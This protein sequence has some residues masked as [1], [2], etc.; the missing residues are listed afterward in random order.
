MTLRE[1]LAADAAAAI[2]GYEETFQLGGKDF[3]C[4][5]RDQPT[6]M[7]LQESGGFIEGV[8]YWLV[9]AKAAFPSRNAWP[10]DGDGINGNAHQV[11]RVTGH[12][13]PAS[14]TLTL[15]IGSFDE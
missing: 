4:V 12:K 11:K 15:H 14:A 9:V 2:A 10:T 5:R 7:D 6:A 1:Q 13:N 3:P 8:D